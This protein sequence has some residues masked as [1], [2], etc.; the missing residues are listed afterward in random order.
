MARN[1]HGDQLRRRIAVEA[2]RL[3][4]ESGLRDFH[5]AKRKAAQR[6]GIGDDAALP[7]NR[8]IDAAL[9]EHQALFQPDHAGLVT[10][11]RRNAADA[12]RFF[13]RFQPRLVGA[14]L[15]GSADAHSAV[16]LHLFAETTI[17]VSVFLME[18]GIDFSETSRSLRYGHDDR[19]EAAVVRFAADGQPFDL[20]VL[21]VDDLRRP[22]LD[23]VSE[24][25]MQRIDRAALLELL[26]RSE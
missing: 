15:D 10:E 8:E 21:A 11:L 7:S 26:E 4:T 9:R 22:P 18:Q 17:D 12:M 20:T 5:A 24:K 2:A 6:L 23:R 3:I 19:R 16:C 13:A 1:R 14:V 25:P